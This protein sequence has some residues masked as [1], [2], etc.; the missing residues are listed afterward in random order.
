MLAPIALVELRRLDNKLVQ[1][2][3]SAIFRVRPA[4]EA[5]EPRAATVIHYDLDDRDPRYNTLASLEDIA[6][7]VQRIS[8]ALPMVE[9][10][11]PT[12]TPVFLDASK[13]KTVVPPSKGLHYPGTN[14]YVQI[15]TQ[16]QQ[17][18]E[19]VAEVGRRVRKALDT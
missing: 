5:V 2:P 15:Y 9:F 14:A 17:V 6:K 19:S 11:S 12:G 1:I 3:S 16:F 4:L 7:V 10:S 18:A 13:I 8:E